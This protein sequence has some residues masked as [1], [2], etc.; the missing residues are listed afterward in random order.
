MRLFTEYMLVGGMPQA[1]VVYKKSGRDFH[2]ADIEKRDIILKSIEMILKL[3]L[4][5]P[6]KAR[7]N[8]G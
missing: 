6:M 4:L 2:A 1:I 7:Q 8:L 5:F 3:I